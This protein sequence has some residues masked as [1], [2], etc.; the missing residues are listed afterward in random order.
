MHFR[1]ST[2]YRLY[3]AHIYIG[4]EK[5]ISE[6]AS[7]LKKQKNVIISKDTCLTFLIRNDKVKVLAYKQL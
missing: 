7:K 5:R 3:F 1:L 6:S 4:Q 2:L